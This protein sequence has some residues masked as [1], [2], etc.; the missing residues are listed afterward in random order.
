MSLSL[1]HLV[2][3][4]DDLETAA[5]RYEE[6]GFIVTPGGEHADG[7]TRNALMPFSD[8]TY[9]ELVAFTNPKDTRDNIWGWRP[10]LHTGGGLVDHCLTSDNL[11]ADIRRLREDGFDVD[12][13]DE[14]G[15]TLPE[16]SQ[17]RWL[18]ARIRQEG[19]VL[20]F[21]IQDLTPRSSRIPAAAHHP[22]GIQGISGLTIS[23]NPSDINAYV[24]LVQPPNNTPN[25][26]IGVCSVGFE[27]KSDSQLRSGPVVAGLWAERPDRELSLAHFP[28]ASPRLG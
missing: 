27:L 13:P 26:K 14:G 21:L 15:R 19:R 2:I 1:D 23:A 17:I 9:L 8:G 18:S 3:P 10:F 12:G 6:L 20:P 24:K 22:N 11:D 7:L 25:V 5:R 16:G 28:G 4:V